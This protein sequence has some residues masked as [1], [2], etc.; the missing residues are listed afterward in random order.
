MVTIFVMV[1]YFNAC[2]FYY[3]SLE[4]NTK[5]DLLSGNTFIQK[6]GLSYKHNIEHYG[7]E[8]WYYLLSICYYISTTVNIIGYGEMFPQSN[9]EKVWICFLMLSGQFMAV[10]FLGQFIDIVLSGMNSEVS[11]T[12]RGTAAE[13]ELQGWLILMTR[14]RDN[15]PIP[16]ALEQSLY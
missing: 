7:N 14:Y 6:Y 2:L 10:Y 12:D 3:I 5:E 15:K 8:Y 16:I 13:I 9:I 4:L 11:G 1:T